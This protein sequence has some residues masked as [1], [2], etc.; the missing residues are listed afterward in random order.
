M[1]TR[2]FLV[3]VAVL[4]GITGC[5]GGPTG[6]ALDGTDWVT[7]P[8]SRVYTLS[9]GQFIVPVEYE[10]MTTEVTGDIW[11]ALGTPYDNI[12][13]LVG[14]Q[15][16]T[17]MSWDDITG[18]SVDADGL[19][20]GGWLKALNDAETAAGRIQ[21]WY[22]L[23]TEEEWEA[24]ARGQA[25]YAAGGGN[26][27][28][29]TSA[30]LG[31]A[32]DNTDVTAAN[33]DSYAAINIQSTTSVPPVGS[34]LSC[35]GLHDMF[36]SFWEWTN[37]T[38]G[39]DR[40][41]RG[42]SHSASPIEAS[43][44]SRFPGDPAMPSASSGVRLVRVARIP[45][46]FGT[47][48]VDG[49]LG[50]GEWDNASFTFGPITVNLPGGATTTA[51][52]FVMND[53]SDLFLAVQF[54][55]D[56]SSFNTH[57]L[58]VRFDENPVDSDWNLGADGNG[59]DGLTVQQK[60]F[61]AR[62]DRLFDSHFNCGPFTPAAPCQGQNDSEWGG[63]TDGTTAVVSDGS[64]T[65]IEVSHPLNTGDIRDAALLQGQSFGLLVFTNVG[66]PVGTAPLVRTDLVPAW[67]A[68]VVR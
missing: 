30:A 18:G 2:E 53:Q 52:G 42:G 61:G 67:A 51:T 29:R 28:C 43:S 23:A 13:Y 54:D 45:P 35:G 44:V 37:T 25:V 1:N 7:I 3:R 46:G 32:T 10:I 47:A 59:D 20:A 48:T 57:T 24:A 27:W 14:Q 12:G 33:L 4:G 5:A 66:G 64:R 15:P 17:T 65:V 21:Y 19:A 39:P 16:R 11:T 62:V 22:R 50:Q 40:I 8:G 34:K 36:G 38:A 9:T 68:L 26:D 56:L 58:A 6:G 41:R 55:Q 60:A 31:D 49:V 63:T